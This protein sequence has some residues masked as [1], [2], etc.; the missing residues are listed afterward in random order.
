MPIVS[1]TRFRLRSIRF[2]PVFLIHAQRVIA[3]VRRA[4]GHLGGA[5]TQDRGLCYW[6]ISVWRD[7]RAMQAFVASGAHRTAMPHL[8]DWGVEAS[9]VHWAQDAADVPAWA[10][11]ARRLRDHGLAPALRYPGP[12]HAERD[13]DAPGE[14]HDLRL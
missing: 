6:T 11:A 2:V 9:V 10:E 5:V 14:G 4:D 8:R 1:V 13:H 12:G 7:D 3:Q